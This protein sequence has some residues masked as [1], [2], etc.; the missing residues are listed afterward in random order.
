M[1]KGSCRARI[2]TCGSGWHATI[3]SRSSTRWWRAS[4][5]T[6]VTSPDRARRGSPR[7]SLPGR[8]PLD[9][10][11]RDPDLPPAVRAMRSVAYANVDLFRGQRW[12]QA[13]KPGRAVRS[14][15][16]AVRTSD[17]PGHHAHAR[18]LVHR[19]ATRARTLGAGPACDGRARGRPP[20]AACHAAPAPEPELVEK[21]NDRATVAD[22][23]GNAA[24]VP[25][26]VEPVDETVPAPSPSHGGQRPGDEQQPARCG[27]AGPGP[28]ERERAADATDPP[29]AA[30]RSARASDDRPSPGGAVRAPRRCAPWTDRAAGT[31]PAN[32][33]PGDGGSLRRRAGTR[34]GPLPSPPAGRTRSP[35][36]RRFRW[37]GRSP[38]SPR[39]APATSRRSRRSCRSSRA[40]S[41]SRAAG[42]RRRR[43]NGA[44]GSAGFAAGRTPEP[45]AARRRRGSFPGDARGR[46]PREIRAP[47][48]RRRRG[49]PVRGRAPRTPPGCERGSC[50]PSAAPRVARQA[51]RAARAPAPR[52]HRCSR[53][54]PPGP[55]TGSA[56]GSAGRAR[57]ACAP[58]CAR[59][60]ASG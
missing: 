41:C 49:T 16:S 50:W 2:G 37:P 43:G 56:E 22:L 38:R 10:L 57:R 28:I 36:C 35:R 59:G 51:R 12:L 3:A 21:G 29:A 4:A 45:A 40:T 15:G 60:C 8:C 39:R 32:R 33:R 47:A 11:F 58:G 46:A 44:A 18:G 13:G 6:T 31:R 19:G 24:E 20:A 27:V 34:S 5:G 17:H 7:C 9:K 26:L 1:T 52:C 42:R 25:V 48:R 55:R 54:R 23:V 14:L 53:S 30:G